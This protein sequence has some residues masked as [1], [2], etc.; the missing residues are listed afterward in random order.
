LK[1]LLVQINPVVGDLDGNA[2]K[3]RQALAAF[4]S[5][6]LAILPE[7]ALTGY[8]PRDLLAQQGFV[9][10][11]IALCHQLATEFEEVGP[12]LIGAPAQRMGRLTNSAWLLEGGLARPVHDKV[13]LPVYDVFDERRHFERGERATVVEIAGR[14][15]AITIC[16]DLWAGE[17]LEEAQD[18]GLR[19]VHQ[20]ADQCD[21]LVNL[22]A[23][24]YSRGKPKRRREVLKAVA[25][26]L[27]RPIAMVNQVGANDELI[28]DGGSVYV[29]PDGEFYGLPSFEEAVGYGAPVDPLPDPLRSDR[30]ALMLGLSDYLEKS[31]LHNVVLGVSGGIDSALVAEIAVAAL[32][33]ERVLGIAMPSRFSSDRSVLDARDLCDR[34]GMGLETLSIHGVHDALSTTLSRIVDASG[35]TDENIQARIRGA[36]VMGVSNSSGAMALATG[37]KSELAVGYCTLYGDMCGGLAPI[38]DLYKTAVYDLCQ[39]ISPGDEGVIPASIQEAAPSAELRPEQK[40]EDSLPPYEDL[41]RILFQLVEARRSPQWIIEQGEDR[42]LVLRIAHLLKVTEFKRWQAA[43]VL[44]VSRKAFGTGRRIPLVW[45]HWERS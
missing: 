44:R 38:G 9:E 39:R 42:D 1:P 33:P 34:L 25:R 16:E 18:Y 32:G 30:R 45:R 19:P 41:D 36:L 12:V 21:L 20:L 22:S 37:N 31:S 15:V 3:I 8:P 23:S 24:P 29:R 14:R 27:G 6:D 28:F 7:L 17:D 11:S 13:L 26:R 43:P 10:A 4:S 35:L 2:A 5:F 40:D